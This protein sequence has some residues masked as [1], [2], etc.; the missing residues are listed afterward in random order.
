MTVFRSRKSDLKVKDEPLYRSR[1]GEV[2]LGALYAADFNPANPV[3][4]IFNVTG[5]FQV[6]ETITNGDTTATI[7]SL[8]DGRHILYSD[9]S[10]GVFAVSDTLTGGTSGATGHISEIVFPDQEILLDDTNNNYVVTKIIIA[11][12]SNSLSLVPSAEFWS[13]PGRSGSRIAIDNGLLSSIN[14]ANMYGVLQVGSGVLNH[15]YLAENSVFVSM[16]PAGV[17]RSADILIF[18]HAIQTSK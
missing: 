11:N 5:T 13:G 7:V 4:T 15:G 9:L 6:G 8:G 10:G 1:E 17:P 2:F 18:G 14:D 16:Y 3:L 12:S